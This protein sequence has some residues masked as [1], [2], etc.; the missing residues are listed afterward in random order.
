MWWRR[1][2]TDEDFNAETRA[3]VDLETD[4]LIAEGLQPEEAR[5][6]ARRAFGNLTRA[7]E[8]FYESRRQMWWDDLRRDL[9]YA[10]RTLARNP[11]FSAVAVL[12][13]ALGIGATVAIFTVVNAVLLRPLPYPDADR[14]IAI[15]HHAP[16]LTQAELQSSTGPHRVLPRERQNVDAHGGLRD[17][18][19]QPDW[20]RPPGAS[21]CACGDAGALRCLG[22]TPRAWPAVLRIGRA[23]GRSARH[24]RDA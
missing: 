19:A 23:K 1:R 18:R 6:E 12:T 9:R 7:Q 22:S 2:R 15:R 4:R 17:A 16:G 11:G 20:Q 13:L 3:H 14:I 8:R 21:T 10:G 24:H 5:I